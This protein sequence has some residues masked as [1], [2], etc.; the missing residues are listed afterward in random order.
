MAISDKFIKPNE[1]DTYQAR[2]S[3]IVFGLWTPYGIISPLIT[4][5]DHNG[6]ICITY[7]QQS[8]ADFKDIQKKKIAYVE[9]RGVKVDVMPLPMNKEGTH[10]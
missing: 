5:I 7:T 10:A 6:N 9:K 1:N 3:D 4:G 2:Q 8:G